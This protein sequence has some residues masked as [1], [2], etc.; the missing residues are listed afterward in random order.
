MRLALGRLIAGDSS[1]ARAFRALFAVP[2]SQ[3]YLALKNNP[4]IRWLQQLPGFADWAAQ[5]FALDR[6]FYD[7]V[8]RIE[9]ADVLPGSQ[10]P[11]ADIGA[12][13]RAVELRTP[14]LDR[15]LVETVAQFDPRALLAFGQKSVLRRLLAR[16]L[17]PDLM[18]AGKRGFVYPSEALLG[19]RSLPASL[20]VALRPGWVQAIWD[21]RRSGDMQR[22]A[23]RLVLLE[24]FA[25]AHGTG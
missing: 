7:A 10:L 2:D 24:T 9:I 23:M 16:Y 5:R 12:M 8:A 14:F 20:P 13:S 6:P 22:L 21:Q 18:Q 15:R 17:P 25:A 11:A 3:L 4:A 1:R 19:S